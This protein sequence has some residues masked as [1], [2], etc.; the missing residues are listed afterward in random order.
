MNAKY[1]VIGAQLYGEMSVGSHYAT[2]LYQY[3]GGQLLTGAR[4]KTDIR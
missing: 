1:L 2:V 4:K 3:I